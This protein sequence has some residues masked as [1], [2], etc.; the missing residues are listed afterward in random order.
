MQVFLSLSGQ[1]TSAPAAGGGVC[2][3]W[4]NNREDFAASVD[5]AGREGDGQR[6]AF[7]ARFALGKDH[8]FWRF[9]E[10]RNC[11]EFRQEEFSSW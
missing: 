11:D 3:H 2:S 9:F 1:P 7:R 4:A 8:V 10:S 5:P 6:M